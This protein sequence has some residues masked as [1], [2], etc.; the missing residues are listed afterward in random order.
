MNRQSFIVGPTADKVLGFLAGAFAQLV[1]VVVTVVVMFMWAGSE[2][3]PEVQERRDHA[4]SVSIWSG[5]GCLLPLL[6]ILLAGGALLAAGT[7][8]GVDLTDISTPIPWLP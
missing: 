4:R 1:G 7:Q 6:F 2:P 5:V 3:T 8:T